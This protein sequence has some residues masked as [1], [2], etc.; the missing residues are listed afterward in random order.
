MTRENEVYFYHADGL[1][2]VVAL[3]DEKQK[4]VETYAYDSFGNLKDRDNALMQPFTYT[5]RE[6]DKETGLYYYRARYYDP[7]EGR[8]VSRDPSGFAGGDV[9][10]YGYV[11]N[12]P[13]NHKDPSGLYDPSLPDNLP[14]I[15]KPPSNSKPLQ[16]KEDDKCP[17]PDAIIN[18]MINSTRDVTLLTVLR[19]YPI[20][21]QCAS[22]VL[23]ILSI[24]DP[25]PDSAQA[26]T[27]PNDII[28]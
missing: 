7:M 20:L 3:T 9:N 23:N 22:K 6:W 4:V 12:N 13:V 16:C 25:F 14:S 11:Q 5:G 28:K 10:L 26:P 2:S 17:I 27:S 18:D 1:G 8:F 15:K 24:L 19:K 21:Q